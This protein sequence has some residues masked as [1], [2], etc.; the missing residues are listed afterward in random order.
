MCDQLVTV[1][2]FLKNTVEA[3]EVNYMYD[4]Y[5]K[6]SA[7]INLWF[8]LLEFDYLFFAYTPE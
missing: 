1:F 8:R 5:L 7:V 3:Y 4:T 6:D 2:S